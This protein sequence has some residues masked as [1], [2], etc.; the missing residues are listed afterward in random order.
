MAM[1]DVL[2][3]VLPNLSSSV[4][5][6]FRE[7]PVPLPAP[8]RLYW[9]V[10]LLCLILR[11][12]S[13]AGT[14]T[15]RRLHVLNWALRSPSARHNLLAVVDGRRRPEDVIVRFDPTLSIVLDFASAELLV[16][17]L[18]GGRVRLTDKGERLVKSVRKEN[19]ALEDE[20]HFLESIGK[21]ITEG[22]VEIMARTARE[23]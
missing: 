12:A 11:D 22:M 13:R 10:V 23:A 7:R 20:R 6:E 5:I 3:A 9:R 4:Q 8:L 15:L 21:S 19:S 16:E 2:S 18:S 17:R 14:S 1:H